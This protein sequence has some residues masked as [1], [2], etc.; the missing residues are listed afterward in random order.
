[1]GI[2]NTFVG[3]AIMF[4]L[5]NIGGFG[6]WLSSAASYTL[7]SILSFFLNKYYT[8][9]AKYWSYRMVAGF[10]VT[11]LVSYLLAYGI[12]KPVVYSLLANFNRS[13]RDN[14]ALILGMSLFTALNYA[15]QRFIAFGG[16]RYV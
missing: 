14:T 11:I 5:Y 10:I 2:I 4:G 16:K 7:T 8:F 9:N 3:T 6:Y 1:V 12:A 15:G 13:I